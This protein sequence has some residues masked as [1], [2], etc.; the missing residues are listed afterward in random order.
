MDNKNRLFEVFQ[1]VN[2]I[3]LTESII[4]EEILPM[5]NRVELIKKFIQECAEL[6]KLQTLPQINLILEPNVAKKLETFG[7]YKFNDN[8]IDV[9]CENRNLADILRTLGHELVHHMQNLKHPLNSDSGK[10][11][12]AEENEANK[13]AGEILRKFSKEHPEIFE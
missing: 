1:K 6:L 9:V 12:S 5:D 11:G 7:N 13:L 3:K 2:K 10:T 4:G 8:I